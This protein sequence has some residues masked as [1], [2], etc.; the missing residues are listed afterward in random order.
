[1]HMYNRRV[2]STNLAFLDRIRSL[3][4]ILFCYEKIVKM[5]IEQINFINCKITPL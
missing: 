1:M 4:K 5:S 3:D 2:F